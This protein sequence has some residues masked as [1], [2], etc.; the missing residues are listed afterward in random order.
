MSTASPAG[1]TPTLPELPWLWFVIL[2]AVCTLLGIAGIV[3]LG[4]TYALTYYS[5]L[6]FGVLFL[7]NGVSHIIGGV[8]T[9][10][11]SSAAL[12][13]LCGALYVLAGWFAITEPL[14][15]AGIY[16]L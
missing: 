13:I 11:L 6:F 2:G 7:I 9:R 12:G 15:V 5:V 10:P 8:F 1:N 14:L 16:T 4:M 3:N